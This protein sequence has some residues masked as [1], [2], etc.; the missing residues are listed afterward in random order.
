MTESPPE[1]N[2][3][4]PSSA[5]FEQRFFAD[6]EIVEVRIRVLRET[7]DHML[8]A[9]QRNGWEEEEGWRI[10]LT[11]GLGYAQGQLALASDDDQRQRLAERLADLESLAAVMKFRTFSFMRDN[12]VLEMRS[13][14]LQTSVGGLN[15][16][17]KRLQPERDELKAE[18]DRLRAEVKAL[19]ERLDSILVADAPAATTPTAGCSLMSF[20]KSIFTALRR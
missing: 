10:L 4:T 18:S 12:Q 7:Y 19:Q 3:T 20:W 1:G 2:L 8:A 14:A 5:D 16:V 11:L 6:A 15:A 13:A 17:I 9:I